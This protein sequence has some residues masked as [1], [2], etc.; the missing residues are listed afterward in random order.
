MENQQ[1]I[2]DVIVVGGGVVGLASAYKIQKRYPRLKVLLLE[3]E[4]MLA[5]HQTGNNSG[6]I[7]SGLYYKP[8]S[9]KAKN[10]VD[11]RRELV[12]FAKDFNV[13]HDVCGKIVVAVDESELPFLD[14]IFNNG[15]QNGV[16]GIEKI[17]GDRI[18]EIEPFCT[19]IAGIWVPCTGIIDY[20]GL[21]NRLGELIPTLNAGS[22]VRT[23]HRVKGLERGEAFSTVYT[24]QGN[25][26]GRHLVF[27]TG[28]QS[29]WM[30]K[31]DGAKD[32]GMRIVGFRGD[33]Y[34]LTQK[35]LHKVRNLIYPVPN[36]A[37]PFLGV[38]FTRMVMGGVECGPNAVFT[39]KREGYGKFSFSLRDT[40]SALSYKGTWKLFFRHWRQGMMEYRRALSKRLFL[41]TLQ[42]LIPSLE[43]E[44][45]E[46][47]R[48]GVRA[49]AL[50]PQGNMIDDFKITYLQNSIHVLNAPSPAAT[51][52]LAIG[53][54]VTDM[55]VKQFNLQTH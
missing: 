11:G 32:L 29:D 7:H 43:M 41:K 26:K 33:Y 42:R 6:V 48:A 34:E 27:C 5:P 30:A 36:P 22:Q 21:T 39:F 53:D 45:I 9:Y 47:G 15:L 3:K 28:L 20:R 37:F 17:N 10:C 4:E 14:K 35:G 51:A 40:V 24:N 44:D 38:H 46:P 23:G 52:C 18:R 50:D 13:A 16:E 25:F 54:A 19:G 8:G 49:M 2:F 31:M 55:A 12:Q 1:D